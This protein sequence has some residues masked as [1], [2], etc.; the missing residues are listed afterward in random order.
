MQVLTRYFEI[1]TRKDASQQ[2]TYMRPVYWLRDLMGYSIL[3][4][5]TASAAQ[6]CELDIY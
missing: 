3:E 2:T 5:F 6:N 4:V 1:P